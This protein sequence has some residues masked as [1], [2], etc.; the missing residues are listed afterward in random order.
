MP[1]TNERLGLLYLQGKRD[2]AAEP[3]LERAI[4]LDAEALAVAQRA[5]H[6][7]RP[8]TR[9]SPPRSRITMP[10]IALEPRATIGRQQ[11]RLFALPCRRL[12]R[13]RGDFRLALQM[14]P[15]ARHL[16]QPRPGAGPAGPLRG[17]AG[18]PSEGARCA[19]RPTT[20]SARSPWKAATWS[21]RASYFSP[22][23]QRLAAVL[24]GGA[25][26]PRGSRTSASSRA[27]TT[28]RPAITRSDAKR[29]NR[30]KGRHRRRSRS[31]GLPFLSRP[32]NDSRVADTRIPDASGTR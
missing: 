4:A 25:R 26:Q 1:A 2:V 28:I 22:G 12:R 5:R 17:G 23:D 10:R 14:S 31:A 30:S 9:T 13:R 6:R 24:P 19:R 8:E 16:D 20:C 29:T 3:L 18:E 21:R 11:S 15:P 7:G 32:G 27:A